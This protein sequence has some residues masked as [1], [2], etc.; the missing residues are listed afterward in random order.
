MMGSLCSVRYAEEAEMWINQMKIVF[1]MALILMTLFIFVN[2][3]MAEAEDGNSSNSGSSLSVKVISTRNS[4]LTAQV[5]RCYNT[6]S[7]I[8]MVQFIKEQVQN[9]NNLSNMQHGKPF[10]QHHTFLAALNQ[11]LV[12]CFAKSKT[13]G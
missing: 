6:T 13:H 12:N 8:L 1:V 3:M 9:V 5:L 10:N 11:A 4:N 2:T 7:S